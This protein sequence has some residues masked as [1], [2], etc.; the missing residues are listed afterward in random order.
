[1]V[2]SMNNNAMCIV[3]P[4]LRIMLNGGPSPLDRWRASTRASPGVAVATCHTDALLR[5]TCYVQDPHKRRDAPSSQVDEAW[6]VPLSAW[7]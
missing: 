7:A 3:V 1:M 4:Q 6:R 2:R 5:D